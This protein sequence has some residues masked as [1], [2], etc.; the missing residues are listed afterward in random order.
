M[1]LMRI[2]REDSD[3]K[4]NPVWALK[5]LLDRVAVL[6]GVSTGQKYSDYLL[7]KSCPDPDKV[8]MGPVRPL[9]AKPD[10]KSCDARGKLV[11]IDH[12]LESLLTYSYR[13]QPGRGDV[14]PFPYVEPGYG[15]L[16]TIGDFYDNLWVPVKA[17]LTSANVIPPAPGYLYR[18]GIGGSGA[19]FP[20]FF[21]SGHVGEATGAARLSTGLVDGITAN[22]STYPDFPRTA[23]IGSIC[24]ISFEGM[25]TLVADYL[26]RPQF[27]L[28]G[29]RVG[30]VQADFPG[31]RLITAVASVNGGVSFNRPSFAYALTTAHG[32][33]YE[34]G[35]WTNGTVTIKPV[36][37]FPCSGD[38]GFITEDLPA[39]FTYTMT[40]AGQT[41]Q[42]AASPVRIDLTRPTI[43]A[44]A[45]TLPARDGWYIGNVVVHFSCADVGGSGLADCPADQVLS[46][47]RSASSTVQYVLD[48]AGNKSNPSNAVSVKIDKTP[49]TIAYKGNLGSYAPGQT[50]D[51]QCVASDRESGVASTTCADIRGPASGFG[52]GTHRFSAN[53]TD[54]AGHTSTGSTSF[55]VV[56]LPGDVTADGTVDCRDLAVVK[57]SYGRRAG[58]AAFDARADTN[59]DGVVDIR[60]LS[61]VAQKLPAGT[62]CP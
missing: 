34:P 16:T 23:C 37:S 49:P 54:V 42:I 21:A 43:T 28:P 36:C 51:I 39:G 45:T 8:V 33:P 19:G 24:T 25:N 55:T 46:Q 11:I 26:M 3:C 41:V 32:K 14:P 58:M 30:I 10:P 5:D 6:G 13:T 17:H 35:S 15:S 9:G 62:T 7:G 29:S 60:D 47:E 27:H 1:V 48:G 20:F 2:A 40:G 31:A 59:G 52:P 61:F 50:I 18:A 12:Y 22:A 44:A 38:R 56:A 53:A 57:A 4:C